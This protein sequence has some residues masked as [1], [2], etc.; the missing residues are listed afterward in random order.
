MR[1]QRKDAEA[2][3]RELLASLES[4]LKLASRLKEAKAKKERRPKARPEIPK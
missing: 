1:S 3:C 4:K 2:D